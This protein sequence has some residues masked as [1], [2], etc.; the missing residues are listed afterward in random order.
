[1]SD[2]TAGQVAVVLLAVVIL[3][4]VAAGSA[5]AAPVARTAAVVGPE[6]NVA[7]VAAVLLQLGDRVEPGRV[8]QYLEVRW[9]PATGRYVLGPCTVTVPGGSG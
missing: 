3:L 2:R 4:G 9:D 6:C 8:I 1:M 7:L 5:S